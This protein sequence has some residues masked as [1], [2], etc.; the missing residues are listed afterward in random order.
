MTSWMFATTLGLTALIC[1]LG[2]IYL[3]GISE[4]RD[5][6]RALT[7]KRRATWWAGAAVLFGVAGALVELWPPAN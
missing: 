3:G 7:C 4:Q 6:E 1:A 5:A 2:A